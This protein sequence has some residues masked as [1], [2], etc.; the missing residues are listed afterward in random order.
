M[1]PNL[2]WFDSQLSAHALAVPCFA[3]VLDMLAH[4]KRTMVAASLIRMGLCRLEWLFVSSSH[5]RSL[6]KS[7]SY[8]SYVVR[9]D[10]GACDFRLFVSY[11]VGLD[12]T[13]KELY[14]AALGPLLVGALVGMMYVFRIDRCDCRGSDLDIHAVRPLHLASTPVTAEQESSPGGASGS[15]SV[16]ASFTVM[17]GC[18]EC[19]S[20]SHYPER[21]ICAPNFLP[22]ISSKLSI[23][24]YAATLFR[25]VPDFAAA[26]LHGVV[27]HFA[28]P[29]TRECPLSATSCPREGGGA[30]EASPSSGDTVS[31][32]E[33]GVVT[34]EARV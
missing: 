26:I 27:Y 2:T 9:S 1:N 22:P 6:C 13:Q 19:P 3:V 4:S 25:Y 15:K 14:G 7:C 20:R 16:S 28:P 12:P 29:Y 32:D 17:I 8:I 31:L 24:T 30:G 34:L 11:G 18:G 5:R 21:N 33:E 10:Q 23:V